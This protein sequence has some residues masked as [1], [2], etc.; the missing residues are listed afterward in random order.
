MRIEDVDESPQFKP[1]S[2][3]VETKEEAFH[4]YHILNAIGAIERGRYHREYVFDKELNLN[5]FELIDEKLESYGF[6][7][8]GMWTVV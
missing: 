4:L 6:D 1:F 3:V 2:I 7:T 5:M 8:F